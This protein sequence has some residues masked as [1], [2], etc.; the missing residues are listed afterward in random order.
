MGIFKLYHSNSPLNFRRSKSKEAATIQKNS[1]QKIRYLQQVSKYI[2]YKSTIISQLSLLASHRPVR[3]H[4]SSGCDSED[5]DSAQHRLCI[6]NQDLAS[7][8]SY[9]HL[10]QFGRSTTLSVP[11][12]KMI[13]MLHI[14]NLRK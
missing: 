11:D 10:I 12:W 9:D 6:G 1:S 3:N 7:D 14:E 4:R 2:L 8:Q 13:F 5:I